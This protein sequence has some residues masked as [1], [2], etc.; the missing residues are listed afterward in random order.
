M[1]PQTI[2]SAARK[3][4]T[5]AVAY[6]AVR[7]GLDAEETAAVLAAA[8]AVLQAWSVRD[9]RDIARAVAEAIRQQTA[10]ATNGEQQTRH[11]DPRS[12]SRVGPPPTPVP[13]SE[14]E[15]RS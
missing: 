14:Q 9:D 10:T 5:L 4:V 1:T 11:D 6:A 3:A 15:T 13:P 8:L 2:H 7:L 12:G